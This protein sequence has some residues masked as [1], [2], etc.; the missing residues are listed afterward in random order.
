MSLPILIDT[1]PGVDDAVAILMALASPELE[2]RAI[3]SVHGNVPLALTDA[4]ARALVAWARRDV[5]VHA[6]AERALLVERVDAKA[7]HGEAGL[8]RA[9]LPVPE[10]P[11]SM[12]HA[13]DIIAH[14]LDEAQAGRAPRL[15]LCPLGPLTN[16]ALAL[17]ARH[18]RVKGIERIVLMGGSLSI[19]GNVT[20]AAEYNIYA[21]PHAARV[22][23]DCGAPI[24]MMPL[25]V[26]HRAIITPERY[27]RLCS[28]PGRVGALM[29]PL[30]GE[31]DRSNPA[32]Y[33]SA[34]GPLHD[35][36]VIAYLLRPELFTGRTVSVEID[37]REGPT[38]GA[39]I[40]DWWNVT[41]RPAHVTA[42]TAI[43]DEGFF[44][45]VAERLA[46]LA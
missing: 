6:G 24:V 28:L 12:A 43:D 14:A 9:R 17:A 5:P 35:P 25:D 29:A 26:T 30:L 44:A 39:T 11:C 41:R 1:D 46:R 16:L 13:V 27:S 4:N 20:P 18:D 36:T 38:R 42:M 2:L 15:T 31:Y 32:R 10:Q 21:D 34:G 40:A 37:S 3:T 7:Y 23:F 33:G 8:G 22:V 45:L 19:G